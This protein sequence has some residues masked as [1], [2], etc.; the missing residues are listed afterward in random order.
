LQRSSFLLR[1][2]RDGNSAGDEFLLVFVSVLVYA[3]ELIT[4]TFFKGA[5]YRCILDSIFEMII[6][7]GSWHN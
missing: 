2:R 4:I 6:A 1:T 3:G 5:S 7:A